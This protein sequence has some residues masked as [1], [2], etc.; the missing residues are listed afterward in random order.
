MY[1]NSLTREVGLK[2][3][4]ILLENLIKHYFDR[5]KSDTVDNLNSGIRLKQDDIL[6]DAAFTIAKVR[7]WYSNTDTYVL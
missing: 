1:S 4:P 6:Y 5:L 7:G 3:G 2:A